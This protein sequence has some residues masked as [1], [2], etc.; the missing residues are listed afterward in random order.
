MAEL[1][2]AHALG[3]I[4]VATPPRS[5][6]RADISVPMQSALFSV[7]QR[8]NCEYTSNE[9]GR[10]RRLNRVRSVQID[11]SFDLHISQLDMVVKS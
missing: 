7:R 1:Q 2:L 3:L 4:E 10:L 11:A 9:A 6:A 5:F 8:R